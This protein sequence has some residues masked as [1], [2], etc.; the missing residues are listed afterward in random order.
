M[1]KFD[2]ANGIAIIDGLHL[3]T[4]PEFQE[5]YNILDPVKRDRV[6]TYI[7]VRAKLDKNAPFFD[8]ED[9]ELKDLAYKN[10]F[11]EEH[12]FPAAA[13]GVIETA[14]KN[15][16]AAYEKIGAKVLKLFNKKI[17]QIT[18][19]IE[20]VEPKMVEYTTSSGSKGFATNVDMIAKSLKEMDALQTAKERLEAKLNSEA[21]KSGR[22]KAGRTPSRLERKTMLKSANK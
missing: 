10:Y 18:K 14:L 20:D 6:F 12:P 11:D 9:S 5:L 15:Y 17:H 4:I 3:K 1:L 22:A 16:I 8:A 7:H 21:E 13:E 2:M 19:M